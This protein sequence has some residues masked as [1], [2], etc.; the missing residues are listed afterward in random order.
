RDRAGAEQAPYKLFDL[1]RSAVQLSGYVDFFVR[2][3][4]SPLAQVAEMHVHRL[5]FIVVHELD[6]VEEYDAFLEA[7]PRAAQVPVVMQ[8]ATNRAVELETK[9]KADSEA[10]LS[11]GDFDIWEKH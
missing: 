5:S 1:I 11:L 9:R 10:S 8:L 2:Y 3:P 7:F 4:E 6:A